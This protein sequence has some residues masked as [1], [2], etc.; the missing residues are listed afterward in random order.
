LSIWLWLGFIAF[1]FLLVSLEFGRM[2][3]RARVIGRHEALVW[4][5]FWIVLSL[6]FCV[7]IYFLYDRHW[8]GTGLAPGHELDGRTA[9]LQFLTGYLIQKALSVDNIFVIALIFSRFRVP[10]EYQHGVL[11]P[12]IVGTILL[13]GIMIAGGVVLIRHL[14]WT[15][16]IFG[17]LV[18]YTAIRMLT[19]RAGLLATSDGVL[20]R[21]LQRRYPAA[22]GFHGHQFTAEVEGERAAT[23][24]LLALVMITGASL[25]FA[26]DSIPAIMA[27]TQ[28]PFI[29]FSSIIFAVLGLHSLYFL[30]ASVLERLQY[31]KLAL[32]CILI[33]VGIKMLL[34]HYQPIPTG[35][36]LAIVSVTLLAGIIASILLEPPPNALVSPIAEELD[37]LITLT[38]TSARRIIVLVMGMT[39]LL[40]G[41]AMILTPGPAILVIPL[42]L[43]ILGTE[44]V[45]ARRLLNRFR[46]EAKQLS[47]TALGIFR[48]R[49]KSR[50]GTSGGA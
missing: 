9:A 43:A 36:A 18:I 4:T 39:V 37:Q 31:L 35:T 25:V 15:S 12:G 24:L 1:I 46:K 6:A 7:A 13:R 45:W 11:V 30:L 10:L 42:G 47:G 41:I 40:V 14:P 22:A 19:H 2:H 33:F 44:F 3:R 28:E 5:L 23:P 16:Y 21:L 17:V 34:A 48:G 26:V 32:V 29:I 27:V 20:M 38:L 49:K 8:L 50:D